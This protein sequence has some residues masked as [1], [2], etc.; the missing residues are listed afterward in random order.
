MAGTAADLYTQYAGRQGEQEGLDYWNNVIK[1][2]GYDAAVTGFKGAASNTQNI[3]DATNAGYY[4][5][6]YKTGDAEWKQGD[7]INLSSYA[8]GD[9]NNLGSTYQPYD[10]RKNQEEQADTFTPTVSTNA[11]NPTTAVSNSYN[12]Q[13]YSPTLVSD[14]LNS[15]MD[16]NS[17]YLQLARLQ[18]DQGAVAR[19]LLNSSIAVGAGQ[20][21]AI[22]RALPIATGDANAMNQAS[23]D[24]ATFQNQAS[25]FNT[26]ASN[27]FAL[28]NKQAL[29]SAAKDYAAAQNTASL[30]AAEMNLRAQLQQATNE[31]SMYNNELSRQTALDNLSY[32]IFTSAMNAGI[33]ADTGDAIAD[34]A[35]I[36][37]FWRQ[38]SEIIP[39]AGRPV[40]EQA[41]E[42]AA[43]EVD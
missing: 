24:N 21:A 17:P 36:D 11:W 2:Q 40:I 13:T 6:G 37:G 10:A 9:K 22:D 19:G 33:Y 7:P 29:D 8:T 3:A 30:Q 38:I 23:R 32:N 4:D 43:A 20:A 28:A 41:I 1:E 5:T 35:R 16:Q 18:S 42:A 34:Q 14:R 31:I 39:D 27:Q 25:E 26:S 15:L 12:A